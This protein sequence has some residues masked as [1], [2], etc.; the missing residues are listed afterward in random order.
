MAKVKIATDWLAGCAGC[1]MSLLDMDER[2]L[3]LTEFVDIVASPI[4][5]IKSPPEVDVAIV[6]GAVA[7]SSN[8]A[9]LKELRHQCKIMVALGDCAV[10]GG[11]AAMRNLVGKEAALKHAYVDTLSTVDGKIPD[12]EELAVLEDKVTGADEHVKVDVY[13][14]G[15]PPSADAIYFALS[16]LVAGRIPDLEDENLKYD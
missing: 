9:V 6:E 7:N 3:A 12:D 4:M 10:F 13:V 1:H 8:L 15:C 16:E 2:L 11:I 5:D 14:P